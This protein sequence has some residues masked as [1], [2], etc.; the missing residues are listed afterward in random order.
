MPQRW[1]PKG[2]SEYLITEVTLEEATKGEAYLKSLVD[3]ATP[4]IEANDDYDREYIIGW[5]LYW[6]GELTDEE[7]LCKEIGAD[8]SNIVCDIRNKVK[9]A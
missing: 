4:S 9:A 2:G 5:G 1:K 8:Y 7:E 3:A 6:D